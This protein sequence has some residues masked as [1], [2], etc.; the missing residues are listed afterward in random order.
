MD[1]INIW[2][3]FVLIIMPAVMFGCALGPINPKLTIDGIIFVNRTTET[4]RN[5]RVLADQTKMFISCSHVYP[6]E[7]CSTS[8]LVKEYRGSPIKIFWEQGGAKK[9]TE[10]FFATPPM[11]VIEDQPTKAWV[12]FMAD[13]NVSA[14]LVQ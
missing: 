4:V 6:S 9:V 14:S 10:E 12:V 7:K 13:G 11:E 1:K 5:V 2:A 8:F 3:V